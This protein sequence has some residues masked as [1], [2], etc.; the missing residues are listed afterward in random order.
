MYTTDEKF[1]KEAIKQAKK[2]YALDETPIGCVIVH[3]ARLLAVDTIEEIL[4]R[5]LL[6][7]LKSQ[8]SEKQVRSLA[9]GVWRSVQC[10]LHWSH[11]RCVP[12]QL[13]SPE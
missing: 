10:M 2:A 9:T 8:Q 4:T 11:V 12:E 13:F 7:M 1:M 3:D 5:I 6:R